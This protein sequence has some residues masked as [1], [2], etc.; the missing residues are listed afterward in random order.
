MISKKIWNRII[1]ATWNIAIAEIGD[2][3]IPVNIKWLNHNY[4]DR[5]FADPFFLEESPDNYIILAEEF[6]LYNNK[7]RICK[8]TVE[9]K[10]MNLIRNETLLEKETHLSFPNILI[11]EGAEVFFYPENNASGRFTIYRLTKQGPVLSTEIPIPMIDPVLLQRGNGVYYLLG[12]L[13]EDANDN[14]LHIYKSSQHM[15]RFE[16]IQRISFS[17]NIA[18]RA[19]NVFEWN[20]KLIAPGQIC[21]KHYG[22]GIS[23]QEIR[24][25]D[26]GSLRMK[27]IKRLDA[28]QVTKMTG[29]HTY[30]VRSNLIVMDGYHYGNEFIHD[31]YFKLRGLKN[32]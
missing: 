15:D 26:N 14:V 6:M 27:E 20:G 4:S 10:E 7:G 16:E 18:R 29:F 23:L 32:M 25:A 31:I 11:N 19:G 12:T 9:K 13:P 22:E 21:N 2:D 3:L 17:D 5:W 1:Q 24:F 28:K 30:N 8:L